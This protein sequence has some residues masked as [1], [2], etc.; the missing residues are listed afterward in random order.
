M[1]PQ[2]V[3]VPEHAWWQRGEREQPH[4][5]G[6]C[7]QRERAAHVVGAAL[8]NDLPRVTRGVAHLSRVWGHVTRC[9]HVMSAVAT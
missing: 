6:A 4:A 2:W 7:A 3:A 8:P 1:G 5:S 9:G